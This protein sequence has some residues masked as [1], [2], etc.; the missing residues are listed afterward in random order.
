MT[1]LDL[2]LPTLSSGLPP[3]LFFH[4]LPPLVNEW[5]NLEHVRRQR[6]W[7]QAECHD[8]VMLE[9]LLWVGLAD[10]PPHSLSM[11]QGGGAGCQGLAATFNH[12]VTQVEDSQDLSL[13]PLV[14]KMWIWSQSFCPC[15]GDGVSPRVWDSKH[16]N[17]HELIAE[18]SLLHV[19]ALFLRHL[20]SHSS[21][22]L[23][24][25]I[26]LACCLFL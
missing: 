23:S 13:A 14:K 16:P 8:T 2:I 4:G 12:A 25:L 6:F 19:R 11:S 1:A 24:S 5:N 15:T 26:W 20:L 7:A 18:E 21:P 10:P 9:W 17:S 22:G 3:T